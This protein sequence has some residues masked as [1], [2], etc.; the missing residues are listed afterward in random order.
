MTEQLLGYLNWL[1]QLLPLPLFSFIGAF[2]EEIIAPIPSP[3]V[4]TGAGSLAHSQGQIWTYL[5]LLAITGAAGKTIASFIVYF[6]ADKGEDV[7]LAKFGKFLGVSHK[8]IET[9]G[10]YLNKGWRD[11]L[12]LFLIRATPILPSGPVSAVCGIV[13][14]NRATF[15]RTTFVGSIF[16]NLFYLYVGFQGLNLLSNLDQIKNVVTL[17][18]VGVAGL[19]LVYVVRFRRKKA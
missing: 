7:F 18:V 12:V 14:I 6:L 13:K 9:I 10:K 16:R 3:F 4:M 8:E 2:L 15:I 11:D 17:V 19:A 5:V 1:A